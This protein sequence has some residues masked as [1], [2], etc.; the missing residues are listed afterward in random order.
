[1]Y[2]CSP[3]T[4]PRN[5]PGGGVLHPLQL[6]EK[7]VGAAVQNEVAVV[8]ATGDE[9]PCTSVCAASTLSMIVVQAES[10]AVDNTQNDRL[11]LRGR[12]L[13]A[14]YQGQHRGRLQAELMTWTVADKT[15]TSWTVSLSTMCPTTTAASCWHSDV[16]GWHSSIHPRLVDNVSTGRH[17]STVTLMVR[18]NPRWRPPPSW[19]NFK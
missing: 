2:M 3:I 12:P 16:A 14:D 4:R 1:M 9:C 6:L 17:D 5:L 10:V 19:K 18:T 7:V 15:C 13:S 8:Q 11:M